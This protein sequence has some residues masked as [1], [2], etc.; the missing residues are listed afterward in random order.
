MEF[1]TNL[2]NIH[3]IPVEPAIG[4][5]SAD[6]TATPSVTIRVWRIR[7]N[8]FANRWSLKQNE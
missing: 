2:K 8:E 1:I 7:F 5:D 3:D 6:D 4:Q